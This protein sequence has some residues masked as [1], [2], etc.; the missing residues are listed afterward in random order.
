[1][2]CCRRKKHKNNL[3][4]K[5]CCLICMDES[6]KATRHGCKVCRK[7]AWYICRECD[8]QLIICPICRTSFNR[9][10]VMANPIN[11]VI[12]NGDALNTNTSTNIQINNRFGRI[13]IYPERPLTINI[14]ITNQINNIRQCYPFFY[15]LKL[16]IIS[17]IKAMIGLI[18]I[19][20]VGKILV[21]FYCRLDC[22]GYDSKDECYCY[23]KTDTKQF[24]HI[25]NSFGASFVTGWITFLVSL[26]CVGSYIK[27]RNELRRY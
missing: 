8:R 11:I 14:N 1:M 27:N 16:C 18:I 10:N 9:Q 19:I 24:W 5:P 20:Y 3:K 17:M 13:R 7:N 23:N 2:L 21:F 15:R 25:F 22:L 12:Q 26:L 6:K 4:D